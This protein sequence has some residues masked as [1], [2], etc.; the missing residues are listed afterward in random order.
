MA[1]KRTS[2]DAISHWFRSFFGAGIDDGYVEVRV[3]PNG[4]GK[5]AGR[6]FLQNA[7]EFADFVTSYDEKDEGV[8]IYYSPFVRARQRG[9]KADLG[10]TSVVWAEID[11]DK[12][13]WDSNAVAKHIHALP[14]ESQPSCC[15]HSGHGLHLY[16]HLSETCTR[17]SDIE[18]VNSLLRD[19]MSGDNVWNADRV[20]RVPWTWNTK[21]KP[22]SPSCSRVP[23]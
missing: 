4:R 10:Y 18:G 11:T 21:A 16:W 20:M 14:Y 22:A 19:M 9:T 1:K 13:E 15:I 3:F 5:M 8:A 17:L 6:G 12:L 2:K 7:V 23:R